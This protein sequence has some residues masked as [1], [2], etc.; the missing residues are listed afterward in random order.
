MILWL[1]WF[2]LFSVKINFNIW[3]IYDKYNWLIENGNFLNFFCV[4]WIFVNFKCKFLLINRCLKFKFLCYEEL[5]FVF[6]IICFF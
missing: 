2:E 5:V 1:N 4:I 3:L 6:V